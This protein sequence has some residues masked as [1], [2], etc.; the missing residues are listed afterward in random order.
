M[1]DITVSE[2]REVLLRDAHNATVD[3]INVCSPAEYKEKSIQGVRSVPLD[4]LQNHL[5]EFKDKKTIYIHC[6][7]GARSHHATEILS[8]LGISAELINV[9]G[10]IIAW[11]KAGYP[12]HKSVKRLPIM[13]QVML[14]AGFFVT[15]GIVLS[16]TV[17]P[18]FIYLSLFVG[19]GLMFAGITGWCTLSYIIERMPWN[20]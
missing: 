7:S 12:T 9:D 20:K 15:L 14:T 2:F 17:S 6:R 16:L 3:F 19:C 5:T 8:N 10:G 4:T 11:E 1:K 13:R 18:P